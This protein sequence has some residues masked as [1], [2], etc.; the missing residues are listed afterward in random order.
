M[1]NKTISG[2]IRQ[3]RYRANKRDIY[4]DLQISDVQGIIEEFDG[5]CAYC[6]DEDVTTLDHPFP[7]STTV[8]NTP[9]NVLPAC[10]VCKS[11]KKN[12]DIVWMFTHGILAETVYVA[13]LAGMFAR[14]GGDVIKEHVKHVTGMGDE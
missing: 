3:A 4:S 1:Q 9:A 10:K 11:A 5:K 12:N 2:W 7:I 13:L 8:P 6:Q 14:R